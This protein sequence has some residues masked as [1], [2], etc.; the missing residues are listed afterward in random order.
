MEVKHS[1][2]AILIDDND[3]LVLIKRTR[4]GRPVYWTTPGGRVEPGDRSLEEA[5]RRELHEEL[6]ATVGLCQQVFLLS[7]PKDGGVRVQHIFV[8]RLTELDLTRRNGPEFE[9]PSRG[10]YDP[11]FIELPDE[12]LAAIDLRPRALRDFILANRD[13]LLDAVG[14]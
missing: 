5:L 6:G 11:D 9:D 1:A 7:R 12:S 14:A 8:A 3:R 4:P 10:R 2:R 13:A